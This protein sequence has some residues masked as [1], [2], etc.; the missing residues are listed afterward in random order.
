ML[1]C[2]TNCKIYLHNTIKVL[3]IRTHKK[4]AVII[5]KFEKRLLYIKVMLLKDADGMANSV[6]ELS[7]LGLHC[8]PKPVCLKTQ[9]HYGKQDIE[10]EN[11]LQMLY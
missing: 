10:A 6:L 4:N 7:D 8:L 1:D 2:K 5:L 9:D 3:K 11:S